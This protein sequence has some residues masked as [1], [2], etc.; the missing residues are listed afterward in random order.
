MRIVRLTSD[1][2]IG[3]F[4]C[5]NSDLNDFLFH[6]SKDY[7]QKLLS[8]TYVIES[9]QEIAGY[10]SVLNDK[11]SIEESDKATW[12]KVKS[13]FRHSKHRFDYPAVKVGKLAVDLKYQ[14]LDLGSNILDFVKMMFRNNNRTGCAFVTVDALN[15]A[16]PFYL[17]NNFKMMRK[18]PV[19][20]V[21]DTCQLYF[22]LNQ[23]V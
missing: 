16:I 15:E 10:F 6:D 4:D 13:I 2:E 5:G 20:N 14:R 22:D 18:Q 21:S 9:G 12:R 19:D 1:Y 8:V 11:I 3:K 7:Q 17:K 23:L